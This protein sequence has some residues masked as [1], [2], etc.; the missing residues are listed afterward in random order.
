MKGTAQDTNNA[1][2]GGSRL[3]TAGDNMQR[4]AEGA[5]SLWGSKDGRQ[6]CSCRRHTLRPTHLP[7]VLAA[8]R[9]L[10][11]GRSPQVKGAARPALQAHKTLQR[12]Y[13]A[14]AS[15]FSICSRSKVQEEPV[16]LLF[17]GGTQ[18]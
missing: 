9:A 3:C 16:G 12:L 6:V 5:R 11:K 2:R 4:V 7:L 17:P 18:F 1:V 15:A 14:G 8:E 10:G 13:P